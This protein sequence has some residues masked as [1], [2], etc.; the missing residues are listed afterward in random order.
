MEG[1]KYFMWGEI[2]I[3][4]FHKID[5]SARSYRIVL[6]EYAIGSVVEL[7]LPNLCQIFHK[8]LIK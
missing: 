8:V 3:R 1:E 6:V 2:Y 5:H 4:V 7:N